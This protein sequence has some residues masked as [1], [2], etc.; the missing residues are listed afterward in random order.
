[1]RHLTS[2]D[3]R[4]ALRNFIRQQDFKAR[5]PAFE[6]G[7]SYQVRAIATF[8]LP[9]GGS[10]R[11]M[12]DAVLERLFPVRERTRSVTREIRF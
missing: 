1:V 4:S 3:P 10:S 9:V 11:F 7:R 8:T 12:S 6:P 2:S 5:F